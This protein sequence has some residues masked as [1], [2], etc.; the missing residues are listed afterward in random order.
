[1]YPGVT[2][3]YSMPDGGRTSLAKRMALSA[4]RQ[5]LTTFYYDVESKLMLHDPTLFKGI[6]FSTTFQESGLK[7][8]VS[9]GYVDF[10]VIDTITGIYK[11]SHEAFMIHLKKKVPYILVLT[12]MRER[13]WEASARPATKDHVLSTAHTEIHLTGKEQLV[14]EGETVMRIQYQ[15]TKYEADRNMEGQRGSFIIKDNL[16]DMAYTLYDCMRVAG[17]IRSVGRE[18]FYQGMDREVHIG[19]IKSARKQ[20][21]S[22]KTLIELGMKE[23]KLTTPMEVYLD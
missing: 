12:Q 15:L 20:Q 16:V 10:I 8:L 13:F 1:M 7:E 17:S 4:K 22:L 9:N 6:G 3:V 23:L 18:K 14:I 5:G 21:E 11:T 2:V 19:T